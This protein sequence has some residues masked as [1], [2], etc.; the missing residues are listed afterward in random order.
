MSNNPITVK[1]AMEV[2]QHEGIVRQAYKDSVGVWTWGV[3]I[4]SSS[5][6]KVDRY[7]NNPQPMQ[8]CLE[9]WLW[10]LEN[11]AKDVREEFDG[12]SLTEAQFAAALS[13]HWNTGA[14]RSATW[15]DQWKAGN[16]DSARRSFMN[17]SKPPEIIPRREAER[18]LFFDGIWSNK[19]TATEYTKVRSNYTPDW[20][21]AVVVDI[22]DDVR[23]ILGDSTTDTPVI[24][25][26]DKIQ[27]VIDGIDASSDV[28]SKVVHYLQQALLWMKHGG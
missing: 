12:H 3:G 28:G 18:D 22:A 20:G 6:H 15:V 23:S 5:G 4:T 7:I 26:A 1:T 16:V 9:I 10:V 19:G 13:F 27:A 24:P 11:Y 25:G 8:R 17:W 21:S 14:I 2:V